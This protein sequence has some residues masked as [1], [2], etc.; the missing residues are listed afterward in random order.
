V[1]GDRPS[2]DE[3]H[4]GVHDGCTVQFPFSCRMLGDICQ[5]QPVR[6]IDGEATSDQIALGRRPGR[7]ATVSAPVEPLATGLAHQSGDPL[8]VHRQPQAKRELGVHSW[9]AVSPARLSVHLLTVFE[10]Q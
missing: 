2:N 9:P 7:A 4:I 10:Q 1:I 5:P 8:V 3:S 6:C